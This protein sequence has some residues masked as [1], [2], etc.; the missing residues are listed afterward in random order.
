MK[1]RI[2]AAGLILLIAGSSGLHAQ[3][4]EQPG[5]FPIDQFDILSS[6]SISLEINL[7]RALLGFVAAALEVEE[8]ELAALIG[9][10][11]SIRVRVAEAGDLDLES[12]R[13]GL[14][15]A[16]GWL[17]SNHWSP[18]LRLREDDEEVYVYTQI[19]DGVMHGIA[20]LAVESHGEAVLINIVGSLDAR[21]I[22]GLA[23]ALDIPQLGLAAGL[24]SDDDDDEDD[25]GENRR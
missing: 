21:S 17:D 10:L 23:Q 11:D 22:A 25:G 3:I 15:A 14:S 18:M 9:G 6:D 5:Y 20:V 7:G 13:S 4:E 2:A 1:P 8:P 16:T 12:V 19:T 24:G